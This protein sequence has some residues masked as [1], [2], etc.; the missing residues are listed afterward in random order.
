MKRVVDAVGH[1][2]HS[3]Q[4]C[5]REGHEHPRQERQR[6]WQRR[7]FLLQS[8]SLVAG[9]LVLRRAPLRA[10]P[11]SNKVAWHDVAAW[12]VEGKGWQKTQRYYDRLPSGAE[13]AVRRAVW[14]L[15]RHSAGMLTRFATDAR[16]IHVRYSLLSPRVAMPHMPATG[17]SGVDL[18][19]LDGATWRWVGVSRPASQKVQGKLA[20]SLKP[21]GEALRQFMLYLPLYNG[22]ESLEIGV[23]DGAEFRPVKP[24]GG[25]SIVFYGTS[26]MHGA[27]ASRP[28]MAIPAIVGRKLG[29]PVINLGFSGN[30]RLEMELA[31]LM[32]ELDAAAYCL[33]CLPNLHAELVKARTEPFVKFLRK[34]KP[35]TPIVLVEGRFYADAWINTAR[36][37]RN[38]G[39]HREFRAAYERLTRAGVGG[40]HYLAADELLGDDNEG[41]TDGS[42]PNDLGMMRY[43]EAYGRVLRPLIGNA[44]PPRSSS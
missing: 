25:P 28:G 5:D 33:D 18:Y 29:R 20:S 37:A 34:Q 30:G 35:E 13:K 21:S 43:A 36:A 24:R 8:G 2:V 10:A 14:G 17:V 3:H 23:P 31:R 44:N 41:T 39:N 6:R 26:I 32:S 42:H 27:C 19:A 9:S 16:E 1:S 22:I 7:R 40:L 11:E 38:Q 15:S 12:G 4:G